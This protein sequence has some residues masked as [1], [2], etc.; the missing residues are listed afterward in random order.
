L[1]IAN[2]ASIPTI[3]TTINNSISVKPARTAFMSA[4]PGIDAMQLLAK[5]AEG[6]SGRCLDGP[7][8]LISR[9]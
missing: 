3:T 6:P 1:G 7:S 9:Y 2:A 8:I 4:N 5:G